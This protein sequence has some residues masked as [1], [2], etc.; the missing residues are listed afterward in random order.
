M[1]GFSFVPEIGIDLGTTNILVYLKG[2]GI[3]LNEPSVVAKNISN[4]RILAVG[5]EAESMIGRTPQNI[6]ATRPMKDGVIADYSTTKQMLSFILKKVCGTAVFKPV[7]I[8]AVPSHITQVEKRAVRMA[9][10][11]SGAKEAIIVEEPWAAALGAGLPIETPGGNMVIDI[12]GGTTDVAIISLNGIVLSDSER[13]GGNKMDE[14]I[15][16]YIKIKYSLLIGDPMA[17][18]IKV[19]IGTAC[20]P[21]KELTME[22]KGRDMVDGNPKTLEIGSAEIREVIHEQLEDICVKVKNILEITPPDL[23]AD[24]IERGITLTGGSSL[25]KGLDTLITKNTGVKVILSDDPFCSVVKGCGKALDMI[26]LI[27]TKFIQADNQN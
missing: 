22:I 26:D 7:V 11:E 1:F 17:E 3:V 8:V 9:T 5:R 24:I 25:L 12:G 13:I 2:K 15:K 14:S 18:E 6:V 21:E 19:K 27:R 10:V 20:P 16:R 4:N 23:C